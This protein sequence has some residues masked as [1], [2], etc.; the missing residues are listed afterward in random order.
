[1]VKAYQQA[2]SRSLAAQQRKQVQ[3]L[4]DLSGTRFV[5][6]RITGD[7]AAAGRR[8][9]DV[10][11]PS[12]TILTSVRRRGEVIMPNGDTELRVG[13]EVTVLTEQ[14]RV[15][16]VRELFGG[17]AAPFASREP[18]GGAG[19]ES[20]PEDPTVASTGG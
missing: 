8:V 17:T 20:G 11:W 7:A 4:R 19:A 14:G 3:Q 13:D 12:R 10:A 18:R 15:D 6:L 2:V 9:R 5:E 1:V 16:Q